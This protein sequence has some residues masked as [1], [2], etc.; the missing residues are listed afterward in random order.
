M[1]IP[2]L[3][4]KEG[5]RRGLSIRT[6]K[7][8]SNCVSKFLRYYRNKDVKKITKKDVKN[9]ID[10]L[11]EKKA[12]G[13]TVNVYLNSIKFLMEKILGRRLM[14]KIKFSKVPKRLPTVLTKE[15]VKNLFNTIENKKHKLMIELMYSA[16]LRVSELTHLRVKDFEFSKNYGWVRKGK[17]SKDR[18]FIIAEKLNKELQEFIKNNNLNYDSYLFKGNKNRHISKESIN[19]IIKK[20]AKKAKIEKNV[21]CHTLRHSFATHLIENGY[22]INDLQSLLGHNSSET[23]KM[24]IH[25]ANPKLINIRSPLDEL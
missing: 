5:L 24:Y 8:Y 2:D 15:E 6:I 4:R 12:A 18:L 17:G 22:S 10:K 25:M 23:T 11:I 13:N 20:A 7:T 14:Y 21:H 19:I 16:G 3:I 9:Y 1:D